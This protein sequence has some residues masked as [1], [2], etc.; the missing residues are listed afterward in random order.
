MAKRLKR[1]F[2]L[3][4][5]GLQEIPKDISKSLMWVFSA[6]GCHKQGLWTKV[7]RTWTSPEDRTR[8]RTIQAIMT[9]LEEHEERKRNFQV[10]WHSIK[11]Q[12]VKTVWSRH[13]VPH[14]Q[15]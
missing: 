6:E 15:R 14:M 12:L 5:K 9:A 11:Q 2:D 13:H 4:L 10:L 1:A 3:N 8:A 7:L